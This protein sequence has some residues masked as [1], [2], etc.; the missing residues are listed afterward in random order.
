MTPALPKLGRPPLTT[1]PSVRLAIMCAA[2]AILSRNQ[3]RKLIGDIEKE[4]ARTI[5]IRVGALRSRRKKFN[6]GNYAR[7]HELYDEIMRICEQTANPREAVINLLEKTI[8][9]GHQKV[10]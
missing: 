6:A 8:W 5:G 4:V 2:V 1:G 3:P 9:H 10:R 7:A